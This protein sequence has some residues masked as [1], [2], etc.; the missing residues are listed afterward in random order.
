MTTTALPEAGADDRVDGVPARFV[1]RPTST[2]E[3]ADV[4]R[5]AAADG[6]TVVPR[7][8][9]TK[10]GWGP[11]PTSADV[12]L[13]LGAMDQVL[14]HQAGD[15]IVE[16]QAGTPLSRVREVV[17]GQGQRLVVDE[18]VAGATV[19]G[20]LAA[21]ASGPERLL[22]GTVR[23]LLI[24]ITVVRADG[25][26]ARAGGRVVKNVAGYDLGKLVV[27]SLGTL[28]V[29]TEAIFRLHPVP[30]L[31]QWVSVPVADAARAHELAHAVVHGQA[32]AAAVEVD[33]D[34][35]GSGLLSVL[36]N[37]REDGVTRRAATV[38]DQLG[39]DA[40]LAPAA[41]DGWGAYPWARGEVGLKLTCVLS[42]LRD[43]LAAAA[44]VG[45]RVRGSAGAGVL[46]AALP[47]SEA[48]AAAALAR[49]RGTCA[50]H[51]GS[52]VVLEAPPALEQALD[53][54]GPVP[55]LDLMRRVK[56]QFDPDHRLSPGRFV[57][58]I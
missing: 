7:G 9:G 54:W 1:A 43:V 5:A 48:E 14:D 15:L 49:L 22:V 36:L 10:L 39:G 50:A 3:V 31:Q 42:G 12:V 23:D 40:E 57:G 2:A 20:S 52:A 34:A 46:Y 30:E 56:D 21:H 32:V 27:G 41:P 11:P 51:G 58:G 33:L 55:A 19:G 6:L 4:M 18:T 28:A 45:A 53:V 29:V 13:D 17:G 8:A 47:A 38:A 24:G 25:V 37:G 16:A 44:D 26:V 35:T